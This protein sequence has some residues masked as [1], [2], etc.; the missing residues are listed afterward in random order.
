MP[1]PPIVGGGGINRPPVIR[2]SLRTQQVQ[3]TNKLLVVLRRQC[4][5]S[6][7]VLVV[8]GQ[9]RHAAR[10]ILTMYVPR[11]RRRPNHRHV[12]LCVLQHL[13]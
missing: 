10:H 12:V 8:V 11:A 4:V 13:K 7:V 6:S 2:S 5:E 3:G 9:H 1:L